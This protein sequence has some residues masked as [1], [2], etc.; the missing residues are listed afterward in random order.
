MYL[1]INLELIRIRKCENEASHDQT[2]HDSTS[3]DIL[4]GKCHWFQRHC[5]VNLARFQ[6]MSLSVTVSMNPYWRIM[7]N[8]SKFFQNFNFPDDDSDRFLENSSK[9]FASSIF[10]P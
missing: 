9:C 7:E 6:I 1:K 2:S 8:S 4:T 5:K 10:R 3:H